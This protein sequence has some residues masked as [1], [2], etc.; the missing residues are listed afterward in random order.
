[1]ES[2][3]W[4]LGLAIGM[5]EVARLGTWDMLMIVPAE[6]DVRPPRMRTDIL[7]AREGFPNV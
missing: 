7:V 1:M 3:V 6:Q 4:R 5:L 2:G